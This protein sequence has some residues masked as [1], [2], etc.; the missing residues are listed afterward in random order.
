MQAK[1]QWVLHMFKTQFLGLGMLMAVTS[2]SKSDD[3]TPAA[4]ATTTTIKYSQVSAL[5][6]T[7][8]ATAGCHNAASKS[9]SY[10]MST[11]AG[12]AAKATTAAA[13]IES[14][15]NPMPPSGTAKTNFDKETTGKANLIEWLKAGAPE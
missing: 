1:A 15:S 10:D 5:I 3:D 9:G 7:S 6:S 13:R 12:V 11:R 8:C 2:C 14:T 4:I